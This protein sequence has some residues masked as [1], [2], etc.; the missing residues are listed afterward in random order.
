ML[1]FD[2]L[3]A[4]LFLI[5][6]IYHR[7]PVLAYL[8]PIGV[9]II[10]LALKGLFHLPRPSGLT[11]DAFPSGHATFF[12][13]LA[14]VAYYLHSRSRTSFWK[15][16]FQVIPFLF[17]IAALTIG[18]ARVYLGLHYFTDILAGFALAYLLSFAYRKYL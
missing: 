15:S 16:D 3:V 11:F 6:L 12:L 18:L 2:Y 13:T 8:V 14:L 7:A 17:F 4:G 9:A 5:F 10:N 1:G